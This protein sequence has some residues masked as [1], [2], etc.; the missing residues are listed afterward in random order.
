MKQQITTT[1]EEG[2]I[3]I[4]R[5]FS[6]IEKRNMNEIIQDSVDLYK[7]SKGEKNEVSSMPRKKASLPK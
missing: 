4:L 1:L 5:K 6:Y 2:T 3:E 7:K